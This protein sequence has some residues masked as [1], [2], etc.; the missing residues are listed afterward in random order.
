MALA[1]SSRAP[2]VKPLEPQ[3]RLTMTF[4]ELAIEGKKNWR[5]AFVFARH[6]A[7]SDPEM[8]KVIEV[9]DGLKK[10]ERAN[11]SPE[12]VCDLAGVDPKDFA[13]EVFREYLSYSN[14]A[15]NLVAAAG[16][17]DVVRTSVKVAKTKEGV[18]DRKMQF[19]HAAFLP[20]RQGGG[21]HVNASANAENKSATIVSAPELTSME[22]DT[23]RYTKILKSESVKVIDAP[24]EAPRGVPALGAS[25]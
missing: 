23:L 15:A 16:L 22:S 20:Q 7:E 10:R 4:R 2:A 13:A 8:A 18:Q 19:D 1:T 6:A 14:D 24:I 11:A 21:I 25:E 12:F 17:P 9:Y 3:T 5:H